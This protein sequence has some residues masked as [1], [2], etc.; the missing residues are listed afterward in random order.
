[1]AMS[2]VYTN[3]GGM[4]VCEERGGVERQYVSDSLG[5]LIAEIDENQNVTYT[6]DYWPYGEVRTST[7]TRR[8]NWGFVGLLG[9]YT[10]F[11]SLLYVRARHYLTQKARWLTVD[12]LWPGPASAMYR[13]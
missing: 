12:S 9:Y 5:S 7:G 11:L 13:C 2:A 8:S 1:M 3:F 6:A 10:D 4:L